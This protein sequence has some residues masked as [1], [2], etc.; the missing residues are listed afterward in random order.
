MPSIAPENQGPKSPHVPTTLRPRKIANRRGFGRKRASVSK[1][2]FQP[3]CDRGKIQNVV[4]AASPELNPS[5][6]APRCRLPSRTILTACAAALTM[7]APRKPLA[8]E[9]AHEH[10]V[11]IRTVAKLV[12]A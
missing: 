4:P 7:V 2:A 1:W 9:D 10:D 3:S 11:G 8:V 12:A 5:T 6:T